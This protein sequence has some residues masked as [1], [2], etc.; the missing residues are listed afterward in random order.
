MKTKA[1]FLSITLILLIWPIVFWGLSEVDTRRGM[2]WYALHQVYYLPVQTLVEQPFFLYDG[3]GGFQVQAP[4]RVLTAG[5]YL[6]ILLAARITIG[7]RH[8]RKGD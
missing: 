8:S 6:A 5:I 4:G 2:F 1:T 7:R 3:D